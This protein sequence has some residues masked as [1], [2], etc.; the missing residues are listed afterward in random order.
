M[1]S[2]Y[3]IIETSQR[4]PGLVRIYTATDR[5]PRLPESDRED[6]RIR[7]LASFND[8]D[9]AV[10]HAHNALRRR[11]VNIDSRLYRVDL[12]RAIAVVESIALSHR[13]NYLDPRL[14][15]GAREAIDAM[16]AARVV[17][18]QQLAWIWS[19]VG[20]IALVLLAAHALTTFL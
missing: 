17:R 20:W 18:Q 2:G 1:E 13:R 15:P 5:R 10:M 6:P 12:P 7:Y 19:L 3:L 14:D 4:H 9:A 8:V 11:L 16:A